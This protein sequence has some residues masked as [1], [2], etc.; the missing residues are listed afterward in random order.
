MSRFL[1]KRYAGI[2]PYTPGEQPRDMQYIKLN[3]NES[4]FPPAPGV[5]AAITQEE[6]AQLNLYSDPTAR[7]LEDAIAARY[8]FAPEQ[9]IAGNGSDEILA[10]CFQAFCDGQTGAAFADITYG[11]YKVFAQLYGIEGKQIPLAEDFSVVPEDYFGA[12]KTIFIANPNAPTGKYLPLAEIEAIV[13]NNEGNLVIVDEAYID[14]GGES[15]A[16]LIDRYDNLLV[17]QTFSKSRSLAGA[18]IGFALGQPQLIADLRA[19]KY[20]FNPY[21]LNRLSIL[22]GAA[23]M[24]DEGYFAACAN[25]IQE[26]RSWTTKTL[27]QRGFTVLDSMA[28][29]VFAKPPVLGGE[30]FYLRLKAKGVLVRHFTTPRIQDY[31]RITIG[32]M[33]QMQALMA[34]ADAVL[35]EAQ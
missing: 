18:R 21:N 31:V 23:A 28:N 9:V 33:A 20:S 6:V 32:D 25:T 34:A 35:K 26:N 8:G 5:M 30:A 12:G 1:S 19:M 14:F 15:A 2:A 27:R 4:P 22:A 7:L 29:F 11:F 16:A 24:A 13:R 10:F 3:T 17:V